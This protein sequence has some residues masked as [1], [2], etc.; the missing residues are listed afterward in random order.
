MPELFELFVF[1]KLLLIL[2][3]TGFSLSVYA[4]QGII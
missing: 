2:I 1:N 3:T 4:Q